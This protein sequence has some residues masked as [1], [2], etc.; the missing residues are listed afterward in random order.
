MEAGNSG[1]LAVHRVES[2]KDPR[3]DALM[4]IYREAHPRSERKPS[5]LLVE[6]IGNPAYCFL[7]VVREEDVVGFTISVCF[8]RSDA[9]LL[10]YMA[11]A[12]NARGQGIG[13]FIFRHLV[14]LQPVCGRYLLAEVDSEKLP[15]EDR[16]DRMRRKRFYR[17]LGC[18]EV[19]GL[20]YIMPRI[21]ESA[22]PAM[23]IL[24]YRDVLPSEIPKA[25]LR[26]WLDDIY[27][28]VY[29]KQSADP[30]IGKMIANL[31]ENLR[32]I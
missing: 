13:Q 12:A 22:P 8:A 28:N 6:M 32:L 1:I 9:C 19:E 29:S 4:A 27:V 24:V 7:V 14:E 23:D 11:I 25:L 2:P 16:S 18:R 26:A 5:S 3:F 15:S 21:S 20:D 10:E 30:Q 31:P 17:N